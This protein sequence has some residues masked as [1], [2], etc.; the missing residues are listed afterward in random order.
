MN[1]GQRP[2]PRVFLALGSNLGD[3]VAHLRAGVRQLSRRLEEV[4]VS[5]VYRTAPAEGADPP[6]YLNA[7]M[8]GCWEGTTRGLLEL[9][10]ATETA[11]GRRR[12]EPGAPRT[13]DVDILFHGDAVVR[14]PDLRVPHPRWD[15]RD[16]VVVPLLELAPGWVD[17]R[18][19]ARVAEVARARGWHTG[20]L[21]LEGG[22]ELLR[23]TSDTAPA[24]PEIPEP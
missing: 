18:S 24:D 19:G 2:T 3:R 7:V 4:Q 22:P 11:E 1:V 17:P 12:P 13:L 23:T 20:T 21:A 14:E 9:A 6:D 16:F 15:Q 5:S 10:R 8:S